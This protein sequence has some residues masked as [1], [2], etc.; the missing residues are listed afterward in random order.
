MFRI[1]IVEEIKTRILGSVNSPPLINRVV[2][3]NMEKCCRAGEATDGNVNKAYAIC[4]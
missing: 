3:E 1:K 4:M 2:H